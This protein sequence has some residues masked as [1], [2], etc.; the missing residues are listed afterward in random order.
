[1]KLFEEY[2]LKAKDVYHKALELLERGDFFDAAEKGWCAVELA[3]KALLISVGIPAEKVENLE[4]SM[5]IF[6]RILKAAK[7][8][9][10]LK[11]YY[12]FNSCLHVMG[13]YRMLTSREE[14]E[15]TLKEVKSWITEIEKL[16]SQLS[17]VNLSKVVDIMNH[18]LKIKRKALRASVEYHETL[19]KIS[20]IILQAVLKHSS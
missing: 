19:N 1:M 9:N 2:L 18:A 11:E 10:L 5:P 15:K 16:I 7:R 4:F 14:I 17:D 6:E 13:F 20:E 3:R 12:R 8:R